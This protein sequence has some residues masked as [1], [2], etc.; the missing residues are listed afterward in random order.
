MH[1]AAVV[2]K[3]GLRHERDRLAVATGHVL[4]DVFVEQHLVG[5]V[6][7]RVVLQVDL[8]LAA[9]R[10][11]VV[12]AFDFHAAALHGDHHLRAQILVMVG[13]SDREVALPIP[14]TIPE[15]VRFPSRIPTSLFAID[16]VKPYCLGSSKRKL[17]KQKNS[18][19]SP[20]YCG[21]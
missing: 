15:V 19:C 4:D 11:F 16:V 12:M 18:A 2:A 3:D 13:G 8:S 5:G 21:P 1:S 20:K 7:K 10:D 17:L 14:A 6:E 9:R